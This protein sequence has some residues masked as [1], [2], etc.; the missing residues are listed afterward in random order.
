MLR[1]ARQQRKLT[2]TQLA[3]RLGKPQ[4]FI[5]KVER[6]ERRLDVVEFVKVIESIELSAPHFLQQYMD[7]LEKRK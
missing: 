1:S 3:E 7:E 6:G 5:A 4:S 2:Q